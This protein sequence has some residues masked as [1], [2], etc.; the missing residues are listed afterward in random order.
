MSTMKKV[1]SL[2]LCVAMLVGTFAL[3]GNVAPV[4]E[5]TEG[6]AGIKSY[7][8]L[9]TQYGTN[10]GADGLTDGFVY[11]GAEVLEADGKPTDHYVMPGDELTVRLYFKS[12][13]YCSEPYII[14]LFDNK[15]FD[16]K[17]PAG[18]EGVSIDADGYTSGFAGAPKNTNHPMIKQNGSGHTI[19][20]KNIKS[21]GWIKNFC[22]FSST[23]L[24]ETDLVQSNTATNIT[25]SNKVYTMQS[26]EWLVSYKV[27]V[28]DGLADGTTGIMDSPDELW[29]VSLNPQGKHDSRRKA[30]VNVRHITTPNI[31]TQSDLGGTAGTMA[32]NLDNGALDHVI[33]DDMYHEFTIG[34]GEATTYTATFYAEDQ[35]TVILQN[36][37]YEPGQSVEFPESVENQLG[38][39]MVKEGVTAPGTILYPSADGEYE[40]TAKA[41]DVSFLRVLTTDKFPVKFGLGQKPTGVVDGV[42]T[43]DVTVNEDKLPEGMTF[44]PDEWVLQIELPIGQPFDLT[45]IPDDAV[46]KEGNEITGW[47]T[48]TVA[49]PSTITDGTIITLNVVNGAMNTDVTVSSTALWNPAKYTI[50]FYL[51]E[52]AYNNGDAPLRVIEDV[53]YNDNVIYNGQDADGNSYNIENTVTDKKFAGWINAETGELFVSGPNPG[54]FTYGDDIVL[55][56]AW[57]EYANSATFMAR[58]YA[59]GEWYEAKRYIY[60]QEVAEGAQAVVTKTE[61]INALSLSCSNSDTTVMYL[62]NVNPD[63]IAAGADH[64]EYI[65]PGILEVAPGVYY[66]PEA[67]IS[68]TGNQVFYIATTYACNVTWMAPAYDEA[69]NTF[70]EANATVIAEENVRTALHA[71]VGNPYAA[72]SKLTQSIATPTGYALAG[73]KDVATGELVTLNENG[74]YEIDAQTKSATLMAVYELVEYPVAFNLRNSD[75]PDVVMLNGTVTLG[76]EIVIEGA[77]FTFNGEA[78]VL[79]EIGVANEDQADGGYD[80]PEG[81]TFAGWTLGYGSSATAAEFPVQLTAQMIRENFAN[82]AIYFNATWEAK[83]YTLKFFITNAEEEEELFATYTVKAGEDIATYRTVTAEIAAAVNEKAPEGKVFSNIWYNKETEAPDTTTRMPAKDVSYYAIYSTATVKVYVDYNHLAEKD[84]SQSLQLFKVEG[85]EIL[86]YGED[87]ALVREEAPYYN[88]SFQTVVMRS[89][90]TL[91]PADPS[92]VIGWNIYHVGAGEDPYTAEWK[93]GINDDG[94]TIAKT[95]LIFQ[96]IW[97]AHKDMLFRVYDTDGNIA[98]ALGKNFKTYFWNSGEIV[99]SINETAINRNTDLYFAYILTMSIEGFDWNEFFNIE[100]W[101]GLSLRFDP[102]A[103]PRSWL[104][105][106]GFKGIFEAIGNALGSLL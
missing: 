95:T 8:D 37:E 3:V 38:W 64:S 90:I 9:V 76:G 2:V 66:A 83:E 67:G 26:D 60:R 43:Y 11:F 102:F 12:N 86:L 40:Y 16:V 54:K 91:K 55:Y 17:L 98:I 89:L 75:T 74:A 62:Y 101:Q 104:T 30:Y 97:L 59:T 21:I 88:R 31:N 44:L 22:G 79:P 14:E 63:T 23:Y 1:I 78:S 27:K 18:T 33:L 92:E 58:N 103:I 24:A 85:R 96:P 35:E 25:V 105:W 41:A 100:M 36:T 50:T 13:M 48:S 68:Y 45:Q 52:E 42:T 4:A 80:L 7:A 49:P 46:V 57:E 77:E 81:Y 69:T 32:A 71:G 10:V 28:K 73:W 70:D 34:E 39:A 106:E 47:D 29:P 53:L 19:T 51:N 20:S 72:T 65:V 61:I 15:F 99:S 84:L 82:G 93:E 56:A 5:A 94:T 6:T 87:T